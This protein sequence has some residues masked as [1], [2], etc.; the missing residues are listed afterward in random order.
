MFGAENKQACSC[1]T[2]LH[3]LWA[4]WS[5]CYLLKILTHGAEWYI[6]SA[7]FIFFGNTLFIKARRCR[8]HP[9]C[10]Q[11][12]SC[13]FLFRK[14]SFMHLSLEHAVLGLPLSSNKTGPLRRLEQGKWSVIPNNSGPV[15]AFFMHPF[16]THVVICIS[17]LGCT[18]TKHL[19]QTSNNRYNC[20]QLY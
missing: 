4:Q 6:Q 10:W 12:Q 15:Y 3:L 11:K 2:N 8:C 19:E 17:F 9:P 14:M 20:K 16:L 7:S 1:D 18:H 5:F 13:H